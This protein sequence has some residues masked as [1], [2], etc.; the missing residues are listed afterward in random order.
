[1]VGTIRSKMNQIWSVSSMRVLRKLIALKIA[2]PNVILTL[3]IELHRFKSKRV[4]A[5]LALNI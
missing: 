5:K 4:Y 3:L 2:D 1:V